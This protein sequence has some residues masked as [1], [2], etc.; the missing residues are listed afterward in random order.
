VCCGE[1]FNGGGGS[2]EI[3]HYKL[4]G[5]TRRPELAP[6]HT[7]Y[8]GC[9]RVQDIPRRLPNTKFSYGSQNMPHFTLSCA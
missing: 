6:L 9:Q 8:E 5:Q 1:A 4:D 3:L 7:E 2:P